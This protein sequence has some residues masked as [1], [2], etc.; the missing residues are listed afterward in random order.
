M[1]VLSNI[2]ELLPR[3]QALRRARRA[4]VHRRLPASAQHRRRALVRA[5]DPAARAPRC[6]PACE[7]TI[8]G[9]EPPATIRALAADDLVVTGYV[10]DVDAVF[11]RLPGVDRAAALRRRRQGQGQPGDELRPAG[12]RD[13]G[14]G[15]GHV[16]LAR[17]RR[18]GRRRS[19]KASPRRS[20]GSI[21]T[22]RCGNGSRPAGA[23]NIRAH[24][25]RDVARAAIARAARAASR[26]RDGAR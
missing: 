6:C 25:S 5:R 22:R 4:G 15:R 1:R 26:R 3:R 14:V 19:R 21:T 2:H 20:P 18:A 9:A 10:P 13:A 17:R 11:H 7:T 24:F 16:A 12:R 23:T 8:V